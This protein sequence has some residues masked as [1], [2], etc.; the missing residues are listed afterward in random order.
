MTFTSI[1]DYLKRL[2]EGHLHDIY[3]HLQLF[4]KTKRKSFTWYIEDL[5]KSPKKTK[6]KGRRDKI[7]SSIATYSNSRDAQIT[8]NAMHS[9]HLIGEYKN[10]T[11]IHVVS[12]YKTNLV[13]IVTKLYH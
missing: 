3:K 6:K 13:L 7:M 1:Y 5:D 4:K 12:K 8:Y 10:L 2:R 11:C 9:D